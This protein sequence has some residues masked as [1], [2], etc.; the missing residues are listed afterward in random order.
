MA[1]INQISLKVCGNPD[2]N[3]G[4]QPMVIFNSPSIEIKD[5]VY[6]GFDAN[7]YFFTIKIEK[8]QV[9]YKLIKNNVSSLGAI[10][11]GCLVFGIAIPKGYKLDA[12]VSPYDVLMELKKGFLARCMTCKDPKSEKYEF[13][14]NRVQPNIL[15]DI[16]ESF[17][18]IPAQMPFHTMNA[19]APIAYVSATED[20]IQELMKD[21]QYP[22]FAKFSEVVVAENVLSNN[23]TPISN[24]SIPRNPEYTIYNDGV[25]QPTIITDP[26]QL[27]TVNGNGDPRFYENDSIMFTL[28]EL[29]NGENVP[30]V[31][32]DRVSEIINVSSKALVKPLTRKIN[33][34]FVPKEAETYFF[35]MRND[36]NLLCGNQKINLNQD[37]SFEL[38]G[39]QIKNLYAPQNFKIQQLR[40]DQYEIKSLSVLSNEIRIITEKVRQS[41]GTIGGRIG[42]PVVQATSINACEVQLVLDQAYHHRQCN[43]EFHNSDGTLLQ[44]TT[45]EFVRSNDGNHIARVYI[46]KSWSRTGTQIRLKYKN[47]IWDSI[48]PLPKDN[49]GIIELRDKDFRYKSI[50][51]FSRYSRV[52]VLAT[53]ILTSLLVGCIIGKYVWAN[54]E[55]NGGDPSAFSCPT[56]GHKYNSNIELTTHISQEH[57]TSIDPIHSNLFEDGNDVSTDVNEHDAH[58]EDIT[59]SGS[60]EEV[61]TQYKCNKCDTE[62][63]SQDNLTKH[64]VDK[65]SN[66]ICNYCNKNF[67]GK[68]DLDKHIKD[69]HHFGC[70]ECGD[71]MWFYTQKELENHLRGKNIKGKNHQR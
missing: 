11:Q 43:I 42:L 47:E 10:R 24:I 67:T 60:K 13:S 4:F 71:D 2:A 5:T 36:W 18:L 19:G 52:I 26:K 30:N 29:L 55:D 57:S 12:G 23:Y 9:V 22:A 27:I 59:T 8:N 63:D 53:I 17:S 41:G 40:K 70:T 51:L 44:S 21:V 7:S 32:I 56:C 68:S 69:D 25:L 6:S 16:A 37:L 33:V 15:D 14:S 49:K 35:T 58:S 54:W 66:Q 65:H 34:V 61:S 1:N 62:F 3:S 64:D 39:E 45:A 48:S 38:S 50:G 31:S 20:K 46:P 28:E